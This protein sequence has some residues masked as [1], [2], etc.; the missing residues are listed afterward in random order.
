LTISLSTKI[1][2][3]DKFLQF[4][5]ELKSSNEMSKKL[6]DHFKKYDEIL[7]KVKEFNF[8]NPFDYFKIIK[9]LAIYSYSPRTQ[10]IFH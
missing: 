5:K 9:Q 2:K 7:N 8:E 6:K 3:E 4:K 10:V 1:D